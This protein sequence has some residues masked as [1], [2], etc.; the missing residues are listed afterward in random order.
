VPEENSL[1]SGKSVS[2]RPGVSVFRFRCAVGVSV[3]RERSSRFA[4]I[5]SLCSY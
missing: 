3:E 2:L 4:P 1:T 5:L